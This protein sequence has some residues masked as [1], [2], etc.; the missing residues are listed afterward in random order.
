MKITLHKS[1]RP[2]LLGNL[3]SLI[4]CLFLATFPAPAST[5]W[6]D[7]GTAGI[8]TPGDGASEAVTGNWNAT[9]T[10]TNW[11]VGDGLNHVAWNNTVNGGDTAVFGGLSTASITVTAG[12]VSAGN[13]TVANAGSGAS[14]CTFSGGTITFGTVNNTATIDMSG[15]LSSGSTGF[16]L[17]GTVLAG[18]ISGG[19]TFVGANN[20]YD[21]IYNTVSPGRV[22]LLVN[23]SVN[24]FTGSITVSNAFE[25]QV[26]SSTTRWDTLGAAANNVTLN[27]GALLL[28]TGVGNR[29]FDH[30]INVI[31]ANNAVNVDNGGNNAVSGAITTSTSGDTMWSVA[32]PGTA[33][34]YSGDLSGFTGTFNAKSTTGTNVIDCT[35]T[36]GGTFFVGSGSLQI[37]NNDTKGSLGT[38]DIVNNGTINYNRTDSLTYSAN[39]SGTGAL[40][41]NKGMLLLNGAIT[42]SGVTT[43]KTNATLA[44]SGSISGPVTL[45][46][47]GTLGAGTA[48][49]GTLTINNTLTLNAGS[50]N[51]MRINKSGGTLTSDLITGLPGLAYAGTL[52]MTAA[53]DALNDGDTFTLFTLASGVYSG[54]FAVLNLPSL[55]AGKSW[56]LSQLLVNGSIRVAGGAAAPTFNPPAGSYAGAPTVT[57]SSLTPGAT[58][59][60][61]TNG[62]T[63]TSGSPSGTSPVTVVV[64]ADASTTLKAYASASGYSGSVVSSA[65]YVTL[66]TPTWT[67]AVGG[68]WATAANWSNNVIATGSGVTVDIST[69]T[70]SANTTITLDSAPTVG[71]L[72]F[73]DAGNA[74]GWI[75]DGGTGGPLTL[76][77]GTNTP[78]ILV[79]NQTATISAVLTGTNG[80][81]MTGNGTLVLAAA[82]PFTGNVTVSSG[83]LQSTKGNLGSYSG[84]G[85]SNTVTITAGATLNV[86]GVAG[87]GNQLGASEKNTLTA[88]GG[89]IN[90]SL[91]GDFSSFPDGPYLWNAQPQR[92]ECHLD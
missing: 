43:V 34:T 4:L 47:G 66:T 42:Y 79:G 77:A 44:G 26:V 3:A 53:G 83:V 64:P 2:L 1:P 85:Q 13:I 30:N 16:F 82:N 87:T 18:T 89:T 25:N 35:S 55:P 39:L 29:T 71:Q 14:R 61:T 75:L 88:N 86:G 23:K 62:T 54:G 57:I 32:Y 20:N 22:N 28:Y 17:S 56:D 78:G 8:S 5:L 84:L 90:F 9:A 11:D 10:V 19:L 72:I 46:A 33:L 80:F 51:V 76:D 74:Y 52:T 63:P 81:T 38:N 68:S 73:A 59:Y 6:Y 37:G 7:G 40:N 48:S 60:Y 69:L 92:R 67:N 45:Q 12:T 27:N 21:S 70:L 58:I 49:V 91:N 50:T 41:V 36:F 24:T 15:A 65:D 31:G